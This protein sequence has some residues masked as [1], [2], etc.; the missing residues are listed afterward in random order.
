MVF[1]AT[2]KDEVYGMSDKRMEVFGWKI[3]PLCYNSFTNIKQA[4]YYT[5][6]TKEKCNALGTTGGFTYE[7][8]DKTI[9]HQDENTVI[10]KHHYSV[11]LYYIGASG[12]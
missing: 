10:G 4:E 11:G 6:N 2:G 12:I 1:Q 7:T 5:Y 9:K 3:L 8:K